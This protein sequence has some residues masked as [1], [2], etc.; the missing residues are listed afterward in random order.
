MTIKHRKQWVNCILSYYMVTT[1]FDL[2]PISA[3][4]LMHEVVP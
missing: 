1:Y 3:S 2:R 4:E